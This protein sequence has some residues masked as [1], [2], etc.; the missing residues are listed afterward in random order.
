MKTGMLNAGETYQAIVFDTETRSAVDLRKSSSFRYANDLSTSILLVGFSLIQVSVAENNNSTFVYD[1]N[2]YVL[3][4][5]PENPDVKISS[6]EDFIANVFKPALESKRPVLL[7]SHNAEFDLN[8]ILAV[9]GHSW[10]DI[11]R[12]NL[13]IYCTMTMGCAAGL[14][15]SLNK[16]SQVFNPENAKLESG[17]TL[18]SKY[19]TPDKKTGAFLDIPPEDEAKLKSYCLKD[20]ELCCYVF[21]VLF[22]ISFDRYNHLEFVDTQVVNEKG[23]YFDKDEINA[24]LAIYEE[25]SEKSDNQIT[26]L[27]GGVITRTTQVKRIKDYCNSLLPE[28]SKID[29]LSES[30]ILPILKD[31]TLD[32]PSVK[33]ILTLRLNTK[34]SSIKKLETAF[35]NLNDKSRVQG[36]LFYHG[37][38]TGRDSSRTVQF[39]NIPRGSS[40]E[41]FF[42]DLADH[43]EKL[44][45]KDIKNNLRGF[46]KSPPG[47]EFYCGDFV[48]IECRLLLHVVGH[49]EY[50]EAIRAGKCIYTD[51]A[52]KIFNV[53]SDQI[54]KSSYE[55]R[56]G[57]AAVLGLGYGLGWKTFKI[58]LGQEGIEITEEF[59]R[60]VVN[61]YRKIFWRVPKYWDTLNKAARQAVISRSHNAYFSCHNNFLSRSLIDG[62]SL[63]YYKPIVSD[64]NVEYEAYNS[65]IG[66]VESKSLYGGKLVE[67][68]M[69]SLAATCLLH[70]FKNLTK[71]DFEV[72]L[73]CHDELLVE[74]SKTNDRYEEFIEIMQL[75]PKWLNK[76]Y[77]NG[78]LCSVQNTNYKFPLSVEGWRGDR[79]RK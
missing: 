53:P 76:E 73:R 46:I 6:G 50:V 32:F 34:N 26:L 15:K 55:R 43:P 71:F 13:F 57:K 58:R 54:E 64:T 56:I 39:Q 44:S 72:V 18:I 49:T 28:A 5:S 19:C 4:D 22:N 35:L 31:Q 10:V 42:S 47:K 74:I 41:T 79:Y 67:N 24:A 45:G 78:L 25:E 70:S 77:N 68:E 60:Q 29:S 12:S 61:L 65:Q 27:S 9:S 40:S 21:K 52:S 75:A 59:A 16:L 66:K 48:G 69:Q 51:F 20:V 62:R 63:H 1:G 7:V 23:L 38:H 37:A 17:K 30:S 3:N 14:P 36:T 33:E 8:V 11:Q 2:D